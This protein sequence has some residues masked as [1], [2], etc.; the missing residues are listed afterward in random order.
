M[1][2]I[3]DKCITTWKNHRHA[4]KCSEVT[5]SKRYQRKLQWIP[6]KRLLKLRESHLSFSKRVKKYW[7]KT[8]SQEWRPNIEGFLPKQL[9]W[10]LWLSLP[11]KLAVFN[12]LVYIKWHSNNWKD[13]LENTGIYF[14]TN[15]CA[16]NFVFS[17]C[18]NT[19]PSSL[20]T[21][22]I[23]LLSWISFSRL[24]LTHNQL[25]YVDH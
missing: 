7:G 17:K 24:Q 6:L 3:Q 2:Q 14:I 21:K 1:Q 23:S 8:D 22:I 18:Y 16:R 10:N 9:S 25:S 19:R 11:T 12:Q 5:K 13:L 4:L 15:Q 20:K